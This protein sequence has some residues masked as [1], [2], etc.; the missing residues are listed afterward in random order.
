MYLYV[1][2]STRSLMSA[3]R[4]MLGAHRGRSLGVAAAALAS[5]IVAVSSRWTPA[6]RLVT[7]SDRGRRRVLALADEPAPA[8]DLRPSGWDVATAADGRVAFDA[9]TTKT[10]D[11]VV[12]DLSLPGMD[13][14]EVIGDLRSVAPLISRE[15]I[16][17]ELW[18]PV[19]QRESHYLRA[20]A[21]QL[22]RQLVDDPDH[23]I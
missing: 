8:T 22:R 4:V 6:T 9:A 3:S 1:F 15:Q 20:Y 18:G 17:C 19:Y 23:P 7:S 14:T 13:R 11:V 12:L 5:V 2:L 10:R 16:L 21:A